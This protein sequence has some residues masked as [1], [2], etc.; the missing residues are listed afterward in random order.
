MC[1]K[2]TLK[3]QGMHCA[4]CAI[5]IEKTLNKKLGIAKASVNYAGESAQVEYD[6]GKIEKKDI[7]DI[8]ASTGEYKVIKAD[9]HAH[10]KM[11]DLKTT[12]RKFILSALFSIPLLLTMFIDIKIPGKFLGIDFGMWLMHD[13]SFII[14]FLI[15]W[16]FHKGMFK[17]LKRFKANMDTLISVGT[18]SAY[19][20]SV[21][22]MFTGGHVYF[23]TASIIIT[24]ILLGKYFEEKSKGRAS[25]AIKKLLSLQVKKARVIQNG[26]EEMVEIDKVKKDDILLIKPGEKIPLDGVITEG[27]TSI[28]ESMLTGESIGVEKTLGST[29]Y[30]ATI[31]GGG[32]I[33]IKVT[34]TSTETA[35]SQIIKLVEE[36][37]NSKAPI[38]KLADKVAGIFVPS[39]IVIATLT[40]LIWLLLTGVSFEVALINAVA[41]L[42]IACPCALGLATPTAIMVGSGKGAE[43][44]VLIKESQALEIAHKVDTMVFDKTGTLTNGA[45]EITDINTISH[46]LSANELMIL[47]CSLEK[48]S[49]HALSTAFDKY[50]VEQKLNLIEAKDVEAIQGKGIKGKVADVLVYLGNERLVQELNIELNPVYK[51]SFDNYASE[52]KTPMYFVKD[53]KVEGIVAVA[54]T[55]RENSVEAVKQLQKNGVEVY[56]ISGDHKITAEAVA[57]KLGIKN[58]IAEV[59][60]NQKVDEV[61]KLQ[62]KG[63][64]VAFVGDG[65]NDAPALAQADLGI[66]V[67]SGTDVAMES[68]SIVLMSSDP[69]KVVTALKLSKK[70]FRTIKQNLFWAFF[71]NS[72]AIPL[73]ALGFLSPMIAAGA[74]SFSSLSVVLNSLRIKRFRG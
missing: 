57:K 74:M 50:A 27:G 49:E 59:L 3:I 11:M 45:P 64:V 39:V 28:D 34:K 41:V 55:V 35:L 16:Q 30:G 62:A 63:K 20:Y 21:Y 29:V 42:V 58:I 53:N 31:N 12:R 18:L 13:L 1:M 51:V 67:G 65:I 15:G 33:K 52:G 40:F 38:Q 37:Q 73:A 61:K 56:M 69:L 23:E 2:E 60:P 26:S 54:D 44:G 5:N 9:E 32:V 19:F 36:A 10:H 25:M 68:G 47:A 6:E 66:A 22:A 43:N 17:Q 70:T 8:I 72:A 4:S 46:D 7:E 48:N 24:L 14:V 71:Y